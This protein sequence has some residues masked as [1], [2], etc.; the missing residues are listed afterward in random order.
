[1]PFSAAWAATEVCVG[2]ESWSR[3]TTRASPCPAVTHLEP[4]PACV[5]REG[6]KVPVGR[7]D[8]T[9]LPLSGGGVC[10][11]KP[12]Q[13]A[14]QSRLAQPVSSWQEWWPSLSHGCILPLGHW[15]YMSQEAGVA[16]SLHQ[17]LRKGKSTM[18]LSLV[19][20]LM[21]FIVTY[22]H[23][24]TA[25]AFREKVLKISQILNDIQMQ[26][27]EWP[28]KEKTS[29]VKIWPLGANGIKYHI[30]NVNNCCVCITGKGSFPSCFFPLRTSNN[31]EEI[32]LI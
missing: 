8:H 26:S 24:Q 12:Q 18:E 20:T 27:L 28:K 5:G 19:F 32:K 30:Q 23:V 14:T 3:T 11:A 17:Q 7:T 21:S 9:C 2:L 4:Q 15:L 29:P 1:M 6:Q 16:S 22:S 13:V 31:S 25:R 10:W